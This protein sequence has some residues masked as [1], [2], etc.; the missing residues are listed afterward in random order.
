[1]YT[2]QGFCLKYLTCEAIASLISLCVIISKSVF[3]ESTASLAKW[4][5]RMPIKPS[6]PGTKKHRSKYMNTHLSRAAGAKRT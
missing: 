4:S 6:T 5:R 2:I 1:M 3:P